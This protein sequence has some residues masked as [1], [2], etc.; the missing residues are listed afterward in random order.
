MVSAGMPEKLADLMNELYALGPAG[1]LTY[2]ADT[3]RAVTGQP[4]RTFR[5]F[6]RDHAAAFNH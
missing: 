4:P 3:V 1:H 5:Q 6:A 2:I